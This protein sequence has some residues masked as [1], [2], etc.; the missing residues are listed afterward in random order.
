MMAQV[1]KGTPCLF[2]NRVNVCDNLSMINEYFLYDIKNISDVLSGSYPVVDEVGPFSFDAHLERANVVWTD[3][4]VR[5]DE[6]LVEK[7]KRD[8]SCSTCDIDG[9]GMTFVNRSYLALLDGIPGGATTAETVL[10]LQGTSSAFVGLYNGMVASF[11]ALS[12]YLGNQD[13]VTLAQSQ[14]AKCDILPLINPALVSLADDPSL[15]PLTGVYPEVCGWAH[16]VTGIPLA[17]SSISPGFALTFITSMTGTS[18]GDFAT[19]FA[20]SPSGTLALIYGIPEPEVQIIQGYLMYLASSLVAPSLSNTYDLSGLGAGMFV[21]RTPRE[22]ISGFVDPMMR[23]F[24]SADA[25]LTSH[26]LGFD[27]DSVPEVQGMEQSR[28]NALSSVYL[29]RPITVHQGI[30]DY[31]DIGKLK[32]I[33]GVRTFP[34]GS[35]HVDGLWSRSNFGNAI[36]LGQKFNIWSEEFG[37]RIVTLVVSR[38]AKYHYY[39]VWV[40]ELSPE[41]FHACDDDPGSPPCVADDTMRGAFNQSSVYR[42]STI[43]TL[44]G[45][46]AA[47]VP[48]R[49]SFTSAVGSWEIYVE[50]ASGIP[51]KGHTSVMV[52]HLIKPTSIFYTGIATPVWVPTFTARTTFEL[53]PYTL[54]RIKFI[55]ATLRNSITVYMIPEIGGSIVV[56]ITIII[57]IAHPRIRSWRKESKIAA[58]SRC[59]SPVVK[60]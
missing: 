45:F 51:V 9:S 47:D 50:K 33:G 44:P 21:R 10:A 5:Y 54:W 31:M 60:D 6:Y 32:S 20:T 4:E 38:E 40:L 16:R 46:M 34:N 53:K 26:A 22:F 29:V 39:E 23:D 27:S 14:F 13:P 52:S 57:A 59:P 15:W 49:A 35:M 19:Y 43:R 36:Q 56:G 2:E 1:R 55:P 41:S 8:A 58:R 28:L 37:G 18:G 42:T 48:N 30:N 17:F 12:P 25:A 11:T 24:V 7:F 3:D